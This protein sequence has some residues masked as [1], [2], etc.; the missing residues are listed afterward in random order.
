MQTSDGTK[1]VPDQ[2]SMEV[3]RLLSTPLPPS[4]RNTGSKKANAKSTAARFEIDDFEEEYK[5]KEKP[6]G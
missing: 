6:R 5:F 2:K 4:L 1:K 3:K